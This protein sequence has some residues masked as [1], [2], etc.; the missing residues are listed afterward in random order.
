MAKYRKKPE[1]IDAFCFGRTNDEPFWFREARVTGRLQ[2][3]V[4]SHVM[5]VGDKVYSV[6]IM[7]PEGYASAFPG[8]YIICDSK[9]IMRVVASEDFLTDYEEVK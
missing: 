6:T 4:E 9:G 7:T 1:V 3:Y 8:D 5:D 2:T